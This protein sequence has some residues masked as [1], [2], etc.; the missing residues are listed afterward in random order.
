MLQCVAVCCSLLQ[1]IAVC[2]NVFSMS[3]CRNVCSRSVGVQCVAVCC[4]VLQCVRVVDLLQ[5]RPS[6]FEN[7]L[8]HTVR[9]R[10]ELSVSFAEESY[11]GNDIDSYN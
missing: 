10:V 8:Q 4:S 2:C 6:H 1:C 9:L 5:K 3:R 7:T 11:H